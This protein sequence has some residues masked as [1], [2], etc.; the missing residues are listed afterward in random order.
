[1]G[2]LVT[3]LAGMSETA[4]LHRLSTATIYAFEQVS[5][6][7]NSYLAYSAAFSYIAY[8]WV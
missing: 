1:M 3:P 6:V 7:S 8:E 5:N 2:T 4:F